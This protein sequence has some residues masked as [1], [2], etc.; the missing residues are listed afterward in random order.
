MTNDSGSTGASDEPPTPDPDVRRA[1]DE[2]QQR[3]AEEQAGASPAPPRRRRLLI[4]VA[5]ILAVAGVVV[6]VTLSSTSGPSR[7]RSSV[8]QPPVS[9]TQPPV[10]VAPPTTPVTPPPVTKPPTPVPPAPRPLS[11]T[12][13]QVAQ[14]DSFWTIAARVA[15]TRLGRSPTTAEIGPVWLSLIQA[16]AP[17]LVHPGNANLIYPGQVL[18]VPAP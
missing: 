5:L 4:L 11:P 2:L 1:I 12:T 8:T 16:N 14:G 15:T 7:P 13:V 17:V 10:S 6:G 9:V 18:A 3:I